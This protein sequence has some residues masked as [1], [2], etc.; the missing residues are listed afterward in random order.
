VIVNG[1]APGEHRQRPVTSAPAVAHDRL[2]ISARS[3]ADEV[4]REIEEVRFDISLV[5]R[6]HGLGN[7]L[8]MMLSSAFQQRLV[9]RFLDERV[10]EDIQLLRR[11]ALSVQYVGLDQEC[12]FVS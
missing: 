12:D 10:F 1:F 2:Q 6:F 4:A 11:E 9:C 5:Q 8:M 7:A 3:G